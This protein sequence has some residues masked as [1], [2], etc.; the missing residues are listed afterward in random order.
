[1]PFT[2]KAIS[3]N[4][5]N[6]D[7][8]VVNVKDFG[9]KG[10]GATDD[11]EAFQKAINAS[12]TGE[13]LFVPPGQYLISKTLNIKNAGFTM[14]GG[15]SRDSKLIVSENFNNG[16]EFSPV[17][18]IAMDN[19]SDA[20]D[21]VNIHD[22]GFDASNDTVNARGIQFEFLI[23]SSSFRYLNF[24][25]F[26]GACLYSSGTYNDRCEMITFEQIKMNP[27]QKVLSE[28]QVNLTEVNESI[29]LNCRFFAK[30]SGANVSHEHSLLYLNNCQSIDIKANAF[31]YS[32]NAPA[33]KTYCDGG[34]TQGI[35]IET[36]T[37]E[38]N[39][40]DITIDIESAKGEDGYSSEGVVI[41]NNRTNSTV[42]KVRFNNVRKSQI[43]DPFVNVVLENVVDGCYFL[44]NS[45]YGTTF[46]NNT[47]GTRNTIIDIGSNYDESIFR[48]TNKN[49][50][51]DCIISSGHDVV[52]RMKPVNSS[53]KVMEIKSSCQYSDWANA[54]FD[55][56]FDETVG[57]TV[58]PRGFSAK[59]VN[60]LP[61]ASGLYG[62]MIYILNDTSTDTH[63]PYIC[64]K[65]NGVDKWKRITLE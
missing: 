43:L 3:E 45:T 64:I 63:I 31:F 6:K 23:Y 37:F 17:I 47:S 25:Y 22:L 46:T 53:E 9:A 40:N 57:A 44:T 58:T 20:I 14:Y 49:K 62:G 5:V 59:F 30:S 27:Y 38:K 13:S 7:S 32:D 42:Y 33:I 51:T 4:N 35:F 65:E 18:K 34:L 2:K 41:G 52:M 16:I 15:N 21:K 1:M 10:D 54:K 55:F 36:N 50:K 19:E 56:I 8:L 26:T 12:Y 28:P 39:Y 11:T 48:V 29:F 60:T 24:D 61:T